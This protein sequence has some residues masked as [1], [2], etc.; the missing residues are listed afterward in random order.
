MYKSASQYL[1]SDRSRPPS[2]LMEPY[3]RVDDLV[4]HP[5]RQQQQQQT[6]EHFEHNEEHVRHKSPKHR[7]HHHHVPD[8]HRSHNHVDM[9]WTTQNFN[10]LTD[11]RV[12]GPPFWFSLHVSAANYPDNPHDLYKTAAK[13]NIL[14][15]PYMIPCPKCKPHALAF[16]EKYKQNLDKIVNSRRGL[17]NFYVD[18]HNK[19]NERY[20]KKIWSYT[21]AWDYYT[22]GATVRYLQY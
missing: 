17:F 7:P 3:K 21:E 9:K 11:P 10:G 22:G 20:G 5:F 16:I 15:I 4:M 1:G 13:N 18:F 6:R 2:H 12:W 8:H 19:V 14:S